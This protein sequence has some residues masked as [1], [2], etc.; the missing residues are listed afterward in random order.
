MLEAITA[1]G[2]RTVLATSAGEPELA[3]LRDTLDPEDV[4]CAVTSS[5]DAIFLGDMVWDVQAGRQAGVATAAVLS[6][7]IP[8]EALK[9]AGAVAVYDGPLEVQTHLERFSQ[10]LEK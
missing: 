1:R 8:R 3:A 4:I 5:A 10:L 6:G 2:W 7:G 9:Q